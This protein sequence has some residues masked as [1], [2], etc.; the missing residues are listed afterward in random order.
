M[1]HP[2]PSKE[3]P[4]P[5]QRPT[6]IALV[7]SNRLE[8]LWS[9]A[10]TPVLVEHAFDGASPHGS[11]LADVLARLLA[12]G[13]GPRSAVTVVLGEDAFTTQQILL[14]RLP[15]EEVDEVL[16]RRAA[17][18][19]GEA[20][21][22]TLYLAQRLVAP[23]DTEADVADS[24]WILHVRSRARHKSLM[25]ALRE[26]KVRVQRV[27]AL[28]DV[29]P[30]LA[31]STP[32]TGGE[33]V[34]TFDG[35]AVLTHL[36]RNDALVQVSRLAIDPTD[37]PEA[38]HVSVVQEVRQVAAFWAKGSRGAPINA[39][40]AVGFAVEEMQSMS[41]P[42]SIA[43]QGAE[44]KNGGASDGRAA[45]GA[46]LA[47]LE[48]IA[49]HADA[50][51]DLRIALPPR[52]TR[53]ALMTAATTALAALVGWYSVA[54]WNERVESRA[55]TIS[56]FEQGMASLAHSREEHAA[57][58]SARS[59]FEI[60]LASLSQ[61]TERGV[62][63]EA[64]TAALRGIFTEPLALEHVAVDENEGVVKLIVRG[65][66]ASDVALAANRLTR[67]RHELDG[68]PNFRDVEIT[69]ATRVPDGSDGGG[70]GFTLTARFEEGGA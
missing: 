22:D 70:L 35:S 46:R 25:F 49:R 21:G 48:A 68:H 31:A 61:I 13:P 3:A 16:A 63:F 44:F 51:N 57:F 1:S 39:V 26:K 17:N 60:A 52:R 15:E 69:P 33:V 65:R 66:I 56:S 50:A 67:L 24:N 14:G 42:L 43:T 55:H 10:G 23:F 20:V 62:P 34:V 45:S 12:D 53:V 6:S 32:Q 38:L 47:F 54:F 5:P 36:T 11:A 59:H 9:N 4:A 2:T 41:T 7:G 19:A 29:L 8:L 28:R 18:L 40:T 64:V 27:V 58:A 30:R 37:A